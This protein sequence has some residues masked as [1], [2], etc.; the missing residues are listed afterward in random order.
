MKTVVV[1][2]LV[3]TAC[4]G[5]QSKQTKQESARAGDQSRDVPKATLADKDWKKAAQGHGGAPAISPEELA[6]MDRESAPGANVQR[7]AGGTR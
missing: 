6:R 5:G 2:A 1:L 4:V 7:D 3:L